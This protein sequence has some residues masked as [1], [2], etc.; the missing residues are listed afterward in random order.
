MR[1]LVGPAVLGHGARVTVHEGA[2]WGC[3][4]LSTVAA[5][6]SSE[7]TAVW[8]PMG[9]V[10][11]AGAC[12]SPATELDVGKKILEDYR[13][14]QLAVAWVIQ[15]CRTKEGRILGDDC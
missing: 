6:H 11:L 10:Q 13:Y 15:S 8:C 5:P 7:E 4:P 3:Q 9:C 2:A 1:C 12:I 14:V